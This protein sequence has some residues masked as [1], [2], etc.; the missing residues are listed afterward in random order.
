MSSRWQIL[1][2]LASL[3][4]VACG[5]PKQQAKVVETNPWADY[6]GTYAPGAAATSGDDDG[7]SGSKTAHAERKPADS[8]ARPART[9]KKHG[10]EAKRARG[11]DAGTG[12][13]SEPKAA[14]PDASSDVRA[15]YGADSGSSADPA[16]DAAP[17]A[18]KT[19]KKRAGAR[20]KAP[21]KKPR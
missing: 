11:A 2:L 1:G 17:P 21:A 20:T 6:K 12:S 8:E 10:K 18:K 5:G 15:V 13:A 14:K 16:G 7:A 4:L 9:D 3:T 19:T